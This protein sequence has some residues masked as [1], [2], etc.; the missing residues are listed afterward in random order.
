MKQ[1]IMDSGVDS[2]QVLQV[3]EGSAKARMLRVL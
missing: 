3:L 2:A 1:G